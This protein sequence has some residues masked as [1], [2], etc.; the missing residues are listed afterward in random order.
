MRLRFSLG[1][2][3]IGH[4]YTTRG[5]ADAAPPVH[6]SAKHSDG[7]ERGNESTNHACTT[8]IVVVVLVAS[9]ACR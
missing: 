5:P 9:G 6:L 3:A 8:A 1:L 4:W 2:K 7:R